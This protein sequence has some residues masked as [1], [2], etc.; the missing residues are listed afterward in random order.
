M[1]NL[2]GALLG[3][4]LDAFFKLLALHGVRALDGGEVLRG[5]GGDAL[6]LHLVALVAHG[7][8]N[9]ENARVEHADDVPGVGLVDDGPV[10]GHEL[11][12]LGQ[13]EGL[14]PLDM[15]ILLIPLKLAGADAHEGD[16]VPVG[17]VH[18]GLNLEHEGGEGGVKGVHHRVPGHPGQGRHGHLQEVLQKRLHAEVVQGGTEE[19]RGELA[20]PHGVDVELIARAVQQFDV[21]RQLFVVG[22]A[23]QRVQRGVAQLCLHLI[24]HL[25]AVGAPVAG[26]RQH[27]L[28]IAV[29]HA[30]K[31]LAAADGPVHRVG[32]DAEDPLNVFH[33][34]KGVARLAVH[35]VDK[36]KDGDVAQRA[37][38]EQLDGLRLNALGGV[39]DHDRAV[40]GH[41]GA[42]GVLAEVLVSGGVQNVDALALIIELQNRRCN[43]NSA[44]LFNVHPVRNGVLGALLALDGTGGLN[45]PAV[46]QQLFGQGRFAGIGVRNDRKGAPGFDF[47]A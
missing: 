39:D 4:L 8:S 33:Q 44:L 31:I 42:V 46:Q 29:V 47:L 24:D 45:R 21:L 19:H 30:P 41:Q 35:L 11:L 38:L 1:E 7:V 43:G 32:L 15:E 9:G 13:T 2:D 6:E 40:G 10:V 34:L 27:A 3:D 28:G 16:P 25:H 36:G 18:V 5:E 20:V 23:D 17:L 14:A 37:D 22:S 26:K 12:G